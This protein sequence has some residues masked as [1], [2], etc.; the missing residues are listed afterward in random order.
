MLDNRYD[1]DD[2]M[3]MRHLTNT[4]RMLG[5]GPELVRYDEYLQYVESGE[6]NGCMSHDSWLVWRNQ[7]DAKRP[8]HMMCTE[9]GPDLTSRIERRYEQ[10]QNDLEGE[11]AAV[12]FK[13]YPITDEWIGKAKE[14][15][16]EKWAQR[17][18]EM[19]REGVPTDLK[20]ACKFASLFA[21]KVFGG[22]I[23]GNPEHQVVKTPQRM[24]DLTDIFDPNTFYHDKEWFGN[25]E[26][27]ESMQSCMPRVNQWYE[28][29]RQKYP[30]D[31]EQGNER[32]TA[33]AKSKVQVE[34]LPAKI[35]DDGWLTPDNIRNEFFEHPCSPLREYDLT[36][37]SSSTFGHT[38]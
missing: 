17:H 12:E 34:P 15:L 26:H 29:F 31:S 19:Q 37:V 25:P 13:F 9:S 22:K 38:A 35:T 14:F 28:E 6:P 20:G 4:Q 8:V 7:Q 23:Y 3:C 24:I 16:K 21:Q 10:L 1:I 33:A 18:T 36:S 32:I 27:E 11:E 2:T 5:K 30:M